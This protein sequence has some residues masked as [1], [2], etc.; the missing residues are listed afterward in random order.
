MTESRPE[1]PIPLWQWVFAGAVVIALG[2]AF[3]FS[4]R[5]PQTPKPKKFRDLFIPGPMLEDQERVIKDAPERR[6]QVKQF[7]QWL[8]E[9]RSGPPEESKP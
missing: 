6:E 8:K 4:P 9:R 2:L 7:E 5:V 3:V 1:P